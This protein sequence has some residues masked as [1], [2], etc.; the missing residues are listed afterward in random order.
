MNVLKNRYHRSMDD[1]TWRRIL[2]P[3]RGGSAECKARETVAGGPAVE[4]IAGDST[5]KSG[6]PVTLIGSVSRRYCFSLRSIPPWSA[7]AGRDELHQA[8]GEHG[9]NSAF[10]GKRLKLQARAELAEQ[11]DPR[12]DG[13]LG[14][15]EDGRRS[16]G[17]TLRGSVRLEA[18]N[19]NKEA[20][21]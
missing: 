1:E 9:P 11:R 21:P 4:P 14:S 2:S 7:K 12:L 8:A 13:P 6:V 5:Y 20:L 3:V 18:V 16:S 19:R 10:V 17:I 15:E